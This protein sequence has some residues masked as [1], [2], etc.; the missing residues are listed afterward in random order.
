MKKRKEKYFLRTPV[1][2]CLTSDLFWGKRDCD[3]IPSHRPGSSSPLTSTPWIFRK[4]LERTLAN[5]F[6]GLK[7]KV[8][9]CNVMLIR[10][11]KV[12]FWTTRF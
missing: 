7:R 9:D 12:C 8:I 2:P 10:R 6:R 1:S 11:G 5:T 4:Q 3:V